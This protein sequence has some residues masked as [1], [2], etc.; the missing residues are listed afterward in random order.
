ML[1]IGN[2]APV[3]HS[4]SDGGI[5]EIMLVTD[6]HKD[7]GNYDDEDN[8]IMNTGGKIP[9]ENMVK[10]CGLDKHVFISKQGIVAVYSLEVTL[11]RQKPR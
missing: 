8:K 5:V 9:I 10:M 7:S 4:L 11:L 6:N 1:N 2:D 3:F